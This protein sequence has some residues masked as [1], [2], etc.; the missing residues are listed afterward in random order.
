MNK[1]KKTYLDKLKE[2]KKQGFKVD[3]VFFE[4]QL[5]QG[6]ESMAGLFLDEI[7]KD[8]RTVD[9]KEAQLVVEFDEDADRAKFFEP[10]GRQIEPSFVTVFLGE[11]LKGAVVV[12]PRTS[13]IVWDL[14]DQVYLT[15]CW[16][17]EIK[18]FM[19]E[20][21]RVS[22]GAET[23]G[24]YYFRDFYFIDDGLLAALIFL[25]VYDPERIK[26]WRQEYF[27]SPEINFSVDNRQEILQ[28]I[29]RYYQTDP[30]TKIRKVDG[31]SVLFPDW[32]FNLRPSKTEPVLRLNLEADSQE[33]KEKKIKEV[34]Q[35]IK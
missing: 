26:K 1:Y 11:F 27:I 18:S 9:K 29:E 5:N 8:I 32:R 17:A 4:I 15:R 20:H 13:R 35:K 19:R 31:L 12:E 25:Q 24:H 14:I 10:K 30:Q 6:G 16:G 2:F 23:S 34:S 3:K 7:F 28:R 22:L 21:P 33:L